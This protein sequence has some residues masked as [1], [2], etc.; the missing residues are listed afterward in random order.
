MYDYMSEEGGL[1]LIVPFNL[2][3]EIKNL[4]NSKVRSSPLRCSV[5]KG[6]LKNFAKFT[7]KHMC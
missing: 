1:A 3:K 7:G 2:K 4:V 6:V 5:E